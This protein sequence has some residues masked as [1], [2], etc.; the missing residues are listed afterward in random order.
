MYEV[1]VV[2]GVPSRTYNPR[3]SRRLVADLE[4]IERSR[5]TLGALHG[6]TKCG[7]SVLLAK[8][9]RSAITIDGGALDSADA[10]WRELASRLDVP[11]GARS[12]FA[13]REQSGSTSTGD[14]GVPL[15]AHGSHAGSEGTEIL[16]SREWDSAESLEAN[17][18]KTLVREE[19]AIAI[20]DFHHAQFSARRAL[21]HV[22]KSLLFEGVPVILASV[23][24]RAYDTVLAE[25][26]MGGR[27]ELIE[28]PA[29]D[30]DELRQIG[31]DGF[32]ALNVVTS[33][34]VLDRLAAEALGSPQLMQL[35]CRELCRDAGVLAASERSVEIHEPDWPDFFAAIA[36]KSTAVNSLTPIKLGP[37]ERGHARQRMR[38]V[39]DEEVDIYGAILKA[40]ARCGPRSEIHYRD[41]RSAIGD[42]VVDANPNAGQIKNTLEHQSGIAARLVEQH[43]FAEPVIYWQSGR[44]TLH[45]IDPFFSFFVR[46]GDMKL[47][48]G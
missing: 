37:K 21:T 14:V 22:F 13:Y 6:P 29:W 28:V 47:D 39:D 40:I 9:V 45:I 8:S 18:R 27:V 2:G 48:R 23:S 11:V 24:H 34:Q 46:W 35:F 4:N 3:D 19:L 16:R 12:S 25:P 5:H 36:R 20:D 41:L 32:S 1:F 38:T 33:D 43:E 7:K 42:V 30:V 31:V 44:E 10:L 17:V 15:V 26:E